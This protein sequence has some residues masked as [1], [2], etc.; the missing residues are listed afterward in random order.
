MIQTSYT[1][2]VL[3]RPDQEAGGFTAEVPALG[4]VT[5]G[6]T[7]VAARAMARDAIEVYLAA[8]GKLGR[9]IP[10][11]EVFVEHITVSYP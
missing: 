5:Q 1:Y 6:N 11:D 4:I 10:D 9:Q 7:L 2:T 8:V 3:F